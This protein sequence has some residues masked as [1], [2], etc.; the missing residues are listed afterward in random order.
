M[1]EELS[2]QSPEGK[3]HGMK[4]GLVGIPSIMGLGRG[5][6]ERGSK[7]WGLGADWSQLMGE[8]VGKD[9]EQGVEKLSGGS[10]ARALGNGHPGRGR[11]VGLG[12][13]WTGCP[14]VV[15]RAPHLPF[16]EASILEGRGG[17]PARWGLRPPPSGS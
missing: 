6:E 13:C 4:L 10:S 11:G 14:L 3:F 9:E 1:E 17:A 15:T 12:P 2:F 16:P 7:P 8:D 5:S